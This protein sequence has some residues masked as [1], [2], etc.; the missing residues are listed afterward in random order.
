MPGR[1]QVAGWP[2]AHRKTWYTK[3][4]RRIHRLIRVT[5]VLGH[6]PVYQANDEIALLTEIRDLLA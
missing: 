1:A 6:Q 2:K 5:P 3:V 4:D